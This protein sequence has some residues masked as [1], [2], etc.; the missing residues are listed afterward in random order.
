[1]DVKRYEEGQ[2]ERGHFAGRSYIEGEER[3]VQ[4]AKGWRVDDGNSV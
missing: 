4:G 2:E 1:M 3:P